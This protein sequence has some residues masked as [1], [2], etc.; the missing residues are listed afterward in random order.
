M[1]DKAVGILQVIQ[2]RLG[3]EWEEWVQWPVEEIGRHHPYTSPSTDSEGGHI[4]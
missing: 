2:D 4:V 3:P 1:V